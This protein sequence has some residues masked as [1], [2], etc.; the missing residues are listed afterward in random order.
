MP[1]RTREHRLAEEAVRALENAL[2]P[3]LKLYERPL[4]E[5]GIDGDIEEF[6][7]DDQTTGLQFFVQVKG[8]DEEELSPAL[9]R[10]IPLE[11]ANYYRAAPMAVLMVLFHAPTGTLYARWFHQYDPYDG[12]GGRRTLT[13]RWQPA[14]A[15]DETT[16][17]RL[18]RDARAFYELRSAAV[19]LPRPLH[20]ESAG[21]H[22]VSEAELRLALRAEAAPR[23]DIVTIAAGPPAAGAAR[24]VLAEDE[25]AVRLA[26]VT[27]ATLHLADG[28]YAELGARQM[29]VDGLVLLALAFERLGQDGIAARLATTYLPRSV[30]AG[31]MDVAAALAACMARSHRVLD[32]LALADALDD[33]EKRELSDAAFVFGLTAV[34]AGPLND[35]E[36]AAYERVLKGRV[37]RRK[38]SRPIEA[39]RAAMNVATFHRSRGRYDKAASHY[40]TAL[41][42]DRGYADRAHFWFERAGAL[43]G[44]H[45]F[46]RAAQ[47][48]RRAIE[49]GSTEPLALALEAD[50]LMFAGSYGD[51]LRRFEEFEQQHG[52]VDDGEY[53]LKARALRH[54]IAL[55]GLE[56]QQRRTHAALLA[57]EGSEPDSPRAWFEAS[58]RQLQADA[59][60]GSAWLNIGVAQS[61]LGDHAVG[62]ESQIASTI[63]IPADHEAW[64][65]AIFTALHCGDLEAL[66]NLLVVGRRLGGDELIDAVLAQAKRTPGEFAERF[67]AAVDDTIERRGRPPGPTV[68]LRALSEDGTVEEIILDECPPS[69]TNDAD[70][71]S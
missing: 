32:A 65:N 45:Q 29:A 60:W 51:A 16:P 12:R 46:A 20:V 3:R 10:S 44:T 63:L 27:S 62:L 9:A 64:T 68:A 39:A 41:R 24:L 35:D 55:T 25:L 13:F 58:M 14:D 69:P 59:L 26:T 43:W 61:D 38:R 2:D 11:T 33:P 53:W 36:A 19:A 34:R 42:L 67:I 5:Y 57:L 7:D 17:E 6:D 54:L 56:T 49:L 31:D 30:F 15:W 22:G 28:S 70:H 71:A 40:E 50:C 66:E 8:T 48:Y 47:A 1:K 37:K 52:D 4:P 21:A 18:A 23:S